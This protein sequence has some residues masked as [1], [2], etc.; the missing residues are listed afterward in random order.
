MHNIDLGIIGLFLLGT[1]WV[2]IVRGKKVESLKDFSVADR[3]FSLPVLVCT[4]A[5]TWLGG[6]SSL[7]LSTRVFEYG[8]PILILVALQAFADLFLGVVVIPKMGRFHGCMTPGD[9]GAKAYGQYAKKIIGLSALIKTLG[10]FA[11][12]VS[13][14][15]FVFQY[16][17][18]IP[19]NLGVLFSVGIVLFYTM[20]GGVRA[21][22]FTDVL[23]FCFIVVSVP[24]VCM[25]LL[26][27]FGGY[28]K[29]FSQIPETHYSFVHTKADTGL[30]LTYFFAQFL[31]I[32]N[33]LILHRFFISRGPKQMSKSM[34]LTAILEFPFFFFIG[35]IGIA[36]YIIFPNIDSKLAFPHLIS[37]FLPI[38]VKGIA[39]SGLMA[40]IMS[41]ADSALNLSTSTF[42]GDVLGLKEKTRSDEKRMRNWIWIFT[43]SAALFAMAIALIFKDILSIMVYFMSFWSPVAVVPLYAAIFGIKVS[44]KTFLYAVLGGIVS[45]IIWDVLNLV[46]LTYVPGFIVGMLGNAVV[47]FTRFFFFEPKSRFAPESQKKI[48]RIQ[49]ESSKK[50]PSFS[51]ILNPARLEWLPAT[52]FSVFVLCVYIA[53]NFMWIQKSTLVSGEMIFLKLFSG[54]LC[55]LLLLKG[56]WPK[57]LLRYFTAYWHFTV[58][59]TLPFTLMVQGLLGNLDTFGLTNLT[60]GLFLM[61]LL[62]SWRVFMILFAGGSLLAFG[63]YILL[64]GGSCFDFASNDI[65]LF[66][67]SIIFSSLMGMVFSRK[68]EGDEFSAKQLEKYQA[69]YISHELSTPLSTLGMRVFSLKNIAKKV[70]I[71]GSKED[72]EG[73]QKNIE[74]IGNTVTRISQIQQLSIRQLKGTNKELFVHKENIGDILREAIDI[75]PLPPEEKGEIFILKGLIQDALISTHKSAMIQVMHNLFKNAYEAF[76]GQGRRG[77][78]LRIEIEIEVDEDKVVVAIQDNGPGMQPDVL[79]N[80]FD[81]MFTTKSSGMG[82]GLSYCKEIIDLSQGEMRVRSQPDQG[83][84]IVMVFEK[85]R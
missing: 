43:P 36:A 62:V 63:L 37:E 30:L 46:D 67:F 53:P 85:H 65:L 39:A 47:F 44:E 20:F 32:L 77:S 73:L 83:T 14:M 25:F 7:G 23:Q 27:Y 75:Y 6:G 15:G 19:F 61:A 4:T 38:G 74:E 31:P 84:E 2:A 72:V 57:S 66:V 56:Y 5:A 21:V 29:F 3:N 71:K 9:M 45:F 42:L 26:D 8:Y 40:V 13:A 76:C 28:Q 1:L 16:F 51:E 18:N 33:P 59:I 11:L 54:F 35:L 82:I 81:P 60:L 68:K 58:M 10:T 70:E 48:I 17:L 64:C 49:R 79:E 52:G 41:S 34:I 55:V 50:K 22:V 69:N 12:Q 80:I 24:S 78:Q